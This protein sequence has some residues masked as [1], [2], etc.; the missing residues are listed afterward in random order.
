VLG[1]AKDADRL[2][3]ILN[4]AILYYANY[5]GPVL[6]SH[7]GRWMDA[8][9]GETYH[10]PRIPQGPTLEIKHNV[11]VRVASPEEVAAIAALQGMQRGPNSFQIY[12]VDD[13]VHFPDS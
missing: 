2:C 4:R 11:P 3:D 12:I 7:D 10:V 5:T 1:D 13:K 6:S 8:K 9:T